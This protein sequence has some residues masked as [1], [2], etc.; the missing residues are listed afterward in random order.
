MTDTNDYI[1][2]GETGD[3]A[4]PA[5]TGADSS[6]I[7]PFDTVGDNSDT[8][9]FS[10]S[11]ETIT[12]HDAGAYNIEYSIVTTIGASAARIMRARLEVDPN[13]TTFAVVGISAAY[14]SN[15]GDKRSQITNQITMPLVASSKVRLEVRRTQGTTGTTIDGTYSRL[16]ITRIRA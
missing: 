4:L 12:V 14:T 8:E 11:G 6:L 9:N 2:V 1:P 13:T 10:L 15:N 5:G 3:T 7:V 16:T